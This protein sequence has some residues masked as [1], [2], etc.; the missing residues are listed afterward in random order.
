MVKAGQS[1]EPGRKQPTDWVLVQKLAEQGMTYSQLA[2]RFNISENS[3]R[4]RC[5]REKWL[6]SYKRGYAASETKAVTIQQN[7]AAKAIVTA[8]LPEIHSR[9][10]T[11]LAQA[12]AVTLGRFASAPAPIESWSDAK[13]AYSV[14]RLACGV[15]KEGTTVKVNLSMFQQ[16]GANCT[17]GDDQEG[18]TWEA[19]IV[20]GTDEVGDCE[21]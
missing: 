2:Q 8:D 16:D 5:C 7:E 12:A 3:I 17:T 15:D 14:Q 13:T 6:V 18:V 4:T 1:P 10:A 20:T 11:L 19:E 21:E 9:T